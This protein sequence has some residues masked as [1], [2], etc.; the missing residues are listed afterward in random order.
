M[1]TVEMWECDSSTQFGRRWGG[2]G[3]LTMRW[4]SGSSGEQRRGIASILA[5]GSQRPDQS[6]LEGW[7]GRRGSSWALGF[8]RG[9]AAAENFGERLGSRLGGHEEEERETAGRKGLGSGFIGEHRFVE[10]RER[11]SRRAAGLR[12]TGS[13]DVPSGMRGGRSA[14][15]ARHGRAGGS[16]QRQRGRWEEQPGDTSNERE[17]CWG[18][19]ASGERPARAAGSSRA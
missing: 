16:Q 1:S 12:S 14:P 17:R 7:R 19:W 15:A 18:S 13:A 9:G 5:K 3:S 10:E 8:G 4:T 11:E 2:R 6:G